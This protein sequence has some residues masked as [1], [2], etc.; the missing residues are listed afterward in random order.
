MR[1]FAHHLADLELGAEARSVL[2]TSITQYQRHARVLLRIDTVQDQLLWCTIHQYE[3]PVTGDVLSEDEL[4]ARAK[5]VFQPLRAAGYVPVIGVYALEKGVPEKPV[6]KHRMGEDLVV[7]GQPV[8]VLRQKPPRM[9][10][11]L[12][13][14][15]W[16]VLATE[17]PVPQ[18]GH[19]FY[20]A[21]AR[22]FW[23]REHY[24][25]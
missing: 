2:H 5:E 19:Q 7:L 6:T 8:A 4:L 15:E 24:R 16:R 20:I 11:T 1:T 17:T 12:Q 23:K 10:F 22:A 18:E 3:V 25:R 21:K 9:L 13:G 14:N